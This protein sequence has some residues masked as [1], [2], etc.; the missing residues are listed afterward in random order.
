ML[1][2][3]AETRKGSYSYESVPYER[4]RKQ[5][6]YSVFQNFT[7]NICER[8]SI[9]AKTDYIRAKALK[10]EI[11]KYII[12]I[13][14]ECFKGEKRMKIVNPLKKMTALI[15]AVSMISCVCET[16][17]KAKNVSEQ[18]TEEYIV[19]SKSD[20]S[21][22][23]LNAEY[24]SDTSEYTE[25]MGDVNISV[26]TLTKEQA[27]KLENEKGV[28][29]IEENFK[30]KGCGKKGIDPQKIS[31]DWNIKMINAD[32]DNYPARVRKK[33][34]KYESE[35]EKSGDKVKIA[36]ID[37][38]V[39]ETG[40][41]Q[42]KERCNL[43]P[44]DA[45]MSPCFDDNTSHGTAIAGIIGSVKDSDTNVG[46]IDTNAEIYSIKVMDCDNTAPVSR[47]IE[48]IY[49]AIEYDVD[50]INMSF[51]TTYNSEALHKAIKDAYKEGILLVAAAGNRGCKDGK[52]EYPAAYDEV[53]AVGSVDAGAKLAED[54]SKGEGVDVLA[55]GELVRTLTNFG[56]E[57]ASSGTSI[58]APHVS[59]MAAVLW[60]RDRSRSADFIKGLI[61]SSANKIRDDGTTYGIA[62][63]GYAQD[64][65]DKYAENYEEGICEVEE[66]DNE[67]I[68]DEA[69]ARVAARWSQNNHEALVANNK[70]GKL[71]GAEVKMIKAG[72]RYNDAVLSGSATNED[73][74]KYRR[75]IWHSLGNDTNYMA[76]I[77]WIGRVIRNK[78]CSTNISFNKKDA[79]GVVIAGFK[80]NPHIQALEKGVKEISKS[81]VQRTGIYGNKDNSQYKNLN[82][83]TK[84]KRLLLLGIELHIITDAFAHK[85]YGIKPYLNGREESHWSKV[86]GTDGNGIKKT[87]NVNCYPSRYRAAGIVVKNVMNQCLQFDTNGVVDMSNTKL[88]KCKQ[89]VYNNTF[90]AE[91]NSNFND[92]FLLYRLYT[93]AKANIK[94]DE[95]FKN[96]KEELSIRSYEW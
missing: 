36:I 22:D 83:N 12:S 82:F 29:S 58:A 5:T 50:I 53:M 47:I 21:Y 14:Y 9:C 2:R 94:N 39:D 90:R 31:A 76:A 69:A 42:I 86:K 18:I 74:E 45:Q 27:K 30:L 20:S 51:G 66:N 96:Y 77:N 59:A 37:S 73:P 23:K 48:G 43:V 44:E 87:D 26:N 49:R 56:L 62:D 81:N 54:S 3:I 78:D 88:I 8:R 24:A 40:D 15:M 11:K 4:V 34:K 52:V 25:S 89:I 92:R 60:E 67:I 33:V 65:Y 1:C 46:G 95:T 17:V 61:E 84:M 72:I 80:D 63:L 41:I 28:V 85:A 6:L 75:R 10:I 64:I 71:T 70:N 32:T 16:G 93:Y 91:S 19:I 55:P 35:E 79:N 38:G 7:F 68:I 13:I 57:T